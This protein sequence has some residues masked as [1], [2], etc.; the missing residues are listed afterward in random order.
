MGH[1]PWPRLPYPTWAMARTAERSRREMGQAVGFF[2]SK[3]T[4]GWCKCSRYMMN[5][6][7]PGYVV[8]LVDKKARL[9]KSLLKL[10]LLMSHNSHRY[11]NLG[12]VFFHR[13]SGCKTDLGCNSVGSERLPHPVEQDFH[14]CSWMFNVIYIIKHLPEWVSEES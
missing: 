1:F 14:G 3:L 11:S 5:D 2:L 13:I 6:G 7:T 4:F 10:Q 8:S 9:W 12:P